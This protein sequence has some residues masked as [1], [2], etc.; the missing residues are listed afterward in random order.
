MSTSADGN[1][2][3]P[4]PPPGGLLHQRRS[5]GSCPIKMAAGGFLIV[6]T[7]G[8]LTLGAKA[9]PG[10]THSEVAKVVAGTGQPK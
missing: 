3:Q 2:P 5:M 6:A 8:Y 7:I 9:K 10:A 1:R 4:I